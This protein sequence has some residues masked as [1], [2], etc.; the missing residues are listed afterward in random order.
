MVQKNISDLLKHSIQ[1]NLLDIH[2]PFQIDGNFGIA[3]AIMESCIQCHAGYVELLPAL[4]AAWP[5]GAMR[6]IRLRGGYT[7]KLEWK[8][9]KL[10]SFFIKA[11]RESRI[12]IHYRKEIQEVFLTAGVWS[13]IK[14]EERP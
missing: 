4:P 12:S 7:A 9:G 8:D 14:F 10:A 2:P 5:E 3:E 6:G 1:Y 11:D 13:E